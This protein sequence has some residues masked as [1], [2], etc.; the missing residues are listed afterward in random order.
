MPS[1]CACRSS[2]TVVRGVYPPVGSPPGNANA[3]TLSSLVDFLV[4]DPS[5]G[6]NSIQPRH[7]EVN[8]ELI[9]DKKHLFSCYDNVLKNDKTIIFNV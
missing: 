8:Q 1:A 9:Y 2:G 4:C 7:I 3:C 5:P 6:G